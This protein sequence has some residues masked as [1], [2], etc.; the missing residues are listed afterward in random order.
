M[1]REALRLAKEDS[2]FYRRKLHGIEREDIQTFE[3]V[4][5]VLGMNAE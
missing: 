5:K 1:F 3:D 4:A 2:P